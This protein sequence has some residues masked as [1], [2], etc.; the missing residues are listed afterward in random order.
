MCDGPTILNKQCGAK[1]ENKF[2]SRAQPTSSQLT[3]QRLL[4]P[5]TWRAPA[6]VTSRCASMQLQKN[7]CCQR[8][9]FGRKTLSENCKTRWAGKAGCIAHLLPAPHPTRQERQR[10]T[11]R[12]G[13][14]ARDDARGNH[15]RSADDAL[16]VEPLAEEQQ[17]KGAR[18]ERLGGDDDGRGRLRHL[19]Q[20]QGPRLAR[21]AVRRGGRWV[22][23]KTGD[24]G[25]V[26][27]VW[28][29][30]REG[31]PPASA[32]SSRRPARGRW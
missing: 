25:G 32:L 18:P 2:L 24:G 19:R 5:D 22:G 27:A 26:A 12:R 16:R 20:R 7:H 28:R 21:C 6:D 3:I 23:G 13:L 15:E 9:V 4:A 1:T 30:K 31:T 14:Q 17:P 29:G 11:H 8:Y 10:R